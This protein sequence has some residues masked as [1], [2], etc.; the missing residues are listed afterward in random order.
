MSMK[1]LEDA[2][3]EEL[4]DVLSAERQITRALRKMARKASS[5]ELVAAFEAHLEE[6]EG[7]IERLEKVFESIDR[8]P[9]AKHCDAMS[10]LIEEGKEIM[11]E[12]AEPEVKDAML[13]A[14]AQKVEHY[15]IATYGTLVTWAKML[16]LDKAASLLE[17]TLQEE[18]Q[19][20][21]KLTVC[22]EVVNK[23]AMPAT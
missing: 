2:F 20:D 14:A 5:E 10:G 6:T 9:R 3:H 16:G 8:K 11:D 4:R 17:E 13:I 18:K 12:D 15:E 23:Q 21:E 22:A 7:Q 19:T 1:S